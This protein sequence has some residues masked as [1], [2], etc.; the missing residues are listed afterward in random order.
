MVQVS[1]SAFAIFSGTR[2]RS[3]W[4]VNPQAAEAFTLTEKKR[5]LADVALAGTQLAHTTWQGIAGPLLPLEAES[6]PLSTG[7]RV[8]P[9]RPELVAHSRVSAH[10]VGLQEQGQAR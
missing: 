10:F 8:L 2:Q 1:S 4:K 9:T 5:Q 7:G 6:A 3:E